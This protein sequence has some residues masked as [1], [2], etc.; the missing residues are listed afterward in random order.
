[1]KTV[2]VFGEAFFQTASGN[3]AFLKKGDTQK[4]LFFISG[5][6]LDGPCDTVHCHAM[7][8]GAGAGHGRGIAAQ[9]GR[10]QGRDQGR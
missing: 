3:A 6:C 7:P 9:V 8:Y 2:K 5:L 1:M 10:L 4:L